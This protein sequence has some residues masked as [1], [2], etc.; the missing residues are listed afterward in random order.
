MSVEHMVWFKFMPEVKDT[1]IQS[2]MDQLAA[3]AEVIPGIEA[4][5]CG[6]NFTDRAQGHTHGLIVTLESPKALEI[7][8]P[9]PEHQKVVAQLKQT[10]DSIIAMDFEV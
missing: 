8:G 3:L 1:Q 9:H 2:I 6:K 10:C 7:Y 4:L 5:K